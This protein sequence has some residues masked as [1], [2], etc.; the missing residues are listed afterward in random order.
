MMTSIPS[1][2]RGRGH[3]LSDT[4]TITDH[5]AGFSGRSS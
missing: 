4:D 5:H 3:L 2:P 1:S